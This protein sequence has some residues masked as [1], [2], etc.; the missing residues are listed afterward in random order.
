VKWYLKREGLLDT[1]DADILDFYLVLAG[2]AAPAL[3][4]KGTTRPWCIDSVYLIDARK[5]RAYQVEHGLKG[6]AAA[7]VKSSI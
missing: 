7:S 6:G 2:P 5:L 3:S 4:S 1:T